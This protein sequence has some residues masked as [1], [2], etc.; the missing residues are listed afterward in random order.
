MATTDISAEVASLQTTAATLL[1]A[2]TAPG[3]VTDRTQ[4]DS[5]GAVSILISQLADVATEKAPVVPGVTELPPT[6]GPGGL[7][8]T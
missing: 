8:L 6:Y 2:L 3:C 7:P 1:T 4:A 5:L